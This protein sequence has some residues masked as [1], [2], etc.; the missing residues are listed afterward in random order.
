MQGTSPVRRGVQRPIAS[1]IGVVASSLLHI[2]GGKCVFT[3]TL[4]EGSALQ[5][6]PSGDFK[7]WIPSV[8]TDLYMDGLVC[9]AAMVRGRPP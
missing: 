3:D 1:Y 6:S 4:R 5:R 9:S 8:S 2:V 7:A